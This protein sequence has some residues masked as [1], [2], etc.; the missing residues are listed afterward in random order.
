MKKNK[1]SSFIMIFI[2][3]ILLN[4]LAGT[5]Y[6][7]NEFF[8]IATYLYLWITLIIVSLIILLWGIKSHL[9]NYQIS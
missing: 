5:F 1:N 9:I 2:G 4:V 6:R 7:Y 3:F 8:S